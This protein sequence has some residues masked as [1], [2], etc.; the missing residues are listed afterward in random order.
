MS[1]SSLAG[2]V[3]RALS[4]LRQHESDNNST[5]LPPFNLDF[6]TQFPQELEDI[7]LG[8]V[9]DPRRQLDN[10]GLLC[11]PRRAYLLA[12]RQLDLVSVMIQFAMNNIF[13]CTNPVGIDDRSGM[14]DPGMLSM[15]KSVRTLEMDIQ[16]LACFLPL[17]Q[18]SFRRDEAF[19]TFRTLVGL[20]QLILS[21]EYLW[22]NEL[23]GG[24]A[25]VA[26]TKWG[27]PAEV[28]A[29]VVFSHHLVAE[30]IG[31]AAEHIVPLVPTLKSVRLE[32][33]PYFPQGSSRGAGIE[34]N[35]LYSSSSDSRRNR[36][37]GVWNMCRRRDSQS[38]KIEVSFVRSEEDR[39][40]E[41][42]EIAQRSEPPLLQPPPAHL[43]GL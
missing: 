32:V 28:P 12:N 14:N 13:S 23:F 31:L 8:L 36:R 21:F 11:R 5:L 38:G 19:S 33:R 15:A 35:Q 24:A 4:S 43:R 29:E 2:S 18:L 39:A 25:T 22:F 3:K 26:D 42:G 20:Q 34:D 1:L 41:A 17:Q 27:D 7:I 9:S 6:C 16:T 10:R 37:I 30:V 40:R